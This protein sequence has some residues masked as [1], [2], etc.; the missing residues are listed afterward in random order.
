M[1]VISIATI[2]INRITAHAKAGM[3][4]DFIRHHD[5]HI[6]LVQEIM[7]PEVLNIQ[8]YETHLNTGT[9]MC[10][11]AIVAK[12][13]HLL[14]NILIIQ[15]GRALAAQFLGIW[16]VNVYAPLGSAQRA[17]RERFFNAD[18]THLLQDTA[19]HVIFG[20]DFNCVLHPKDTT[21]R[22]HTSS[23]LMEIVRGIAL[24]NAW[25]QN[26]TH[27][28]YTH[29]S[30]TSASTIYRFYMTRDLMT[31][32]LGIQILPA[33]FTDHNVVA[34]RI[35]AINLEVRRGW[36]RWKMNP[37]TMDNEGVKMQIRHEF[38]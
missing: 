25:T 29:Y 27:P 38:E 32:K 21:G 18:L 3:V 23:A 30:P 19:T 24:T 8:G 14:T 16:L 35:A 13:E 1:N 17:A 9:A 26:P 34:L 4:A 5:F 31:Q 11:T 12:R 6:I 10:G 36:R 37:H 22:F 7:S 28:V 2:N 20:G 15:S 33:A